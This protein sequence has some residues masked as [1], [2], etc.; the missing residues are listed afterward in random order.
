MKPS[1][2]LLLLYLLI[3]LLFIIFQL[4]RFKNRL[5]L[6]VD[7][8]D[9]IGR[10]I[11]DTLKNDYNLTVFAPPAETKAYL[12]HF[13]V[14]RGFWGRL[15]KGNLFQDLGLKTAWVN[16]E[17][18]Y[19]DFKFKPTRYA[20][21]NKPSKGHN[22]PVVATRYFFE[23]DPE[24]MIQN[25]Y[26]ETVNVMVVKYQNPEHASFWFNSYFERIRIALVERRT[27]ENLVNYD[28][29][30]ESGS[31]AAVCQWISGPWETAIMVPFSQCD[32]DSLKAR[33]L[34]DA[35]RDRVFEYYQGFKNPPEGS[36]PSGG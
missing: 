15:A 31:D 30:N 9:N 33:Q 12:V 13:G 7:S 8:T 26:E 24:Q 5:D 11:A 19:I 1:N 16:S 28:E 3:L 2:K 35:I 20:L 10:N 4:L 18:G 23:T 14:T 17:F 29:K 34:C 25:I 22:K 32:G 27:R 21:F 36:E 6:N